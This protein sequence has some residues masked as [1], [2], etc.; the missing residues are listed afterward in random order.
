M[1][2]EIRHVRPSIDYSK[3]PV[4][5]AGKWVVIRRSTQQ[6]MGAGDT[7][8]EAFEE[9]GISLGSPEMREVVVTRVPS[10]I[11]VFDT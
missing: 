7:P 6:P 3:I 2:E 5:L 1:A 9:A 4:A 8:E 10:G 11:E